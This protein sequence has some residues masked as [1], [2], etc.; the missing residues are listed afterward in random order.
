MLE[1]TSRSRGFQPSP[2]LWSVWR[3]HTSTG[4]RGVDEHRGLFE[5]QL[6]GLPPAATW[7][8]RHSLTADPATEGAPDGSDAGPLQLSYPRLRTSIEVR[9]SRQVG[10]HLPS[11]ARSNTVPV[12]FRN[13]LR[14]DPTVVDWAHEVVSEALVDVEQSA[15]RAHHRAMEVAGEPLVVTASTDAAQQ[16]PG[17]ETGW[18]SCAD[19]DHHPVTAARCQASFLDCFHCGNCV[20]TQDHLPRLLGL[21]D[22]LAAR[23]AQLSEA[24]WWIRYGRTW[25]AIRHD[26]LAKFSPAEVA[27]AAITKEPDTQLNLVEAPWELP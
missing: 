20:I 13:Y 1:L 22:A 7:V 15:L 12:L 16:N 11:A 23:R 10:G 2:L 27:Q 8:A 6:H 19:H 24:D 3:Q 21:L 17:V 14:G 26:V 4:A 9:R 25:A 5:R 18:T